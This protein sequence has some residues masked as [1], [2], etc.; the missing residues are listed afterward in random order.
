MLTSLG[1]TEGDVARELNDDEVAAI[2]AAD[3]EAQRAVRHWRQ[4]TTAP[5]PY[6][7]DLERG[8]EP[9]TPEN[10][11][12]IQLPEY[13][14]GE[15]MATPI[16]QVDEDIMALDAGD[17][18]RIELA[19]AVEVPYTGPSIEEI[20]KKQRVAK[21][22]E[23]M[24]PPGTRGAIYEG[25]DGKTAFLYPDKG[26]VQIYD[27][28][29][30][31][32]QEVNPNLVRSIEKNL[33][34]YRRYAERINLPKPQPVQ[35]V[36]VPKKGK[37]TGQG[38]PALKEPGLGSGAQILPPGEVPAPPPPDASA[39]AMDVFTT[40]PIPGPNIPSRVEARTFVPPL[41]QASEAVS[42]EEP[43]TPTPTPELPETPTPTTEQPQP[44]P[45]T[46]VKLV[47]NDGTQFTLDPDT[48]DITH[49]GSGE[50]F[51]FGSDVY[52]NVVKVLKP[53]EA[54]APPEA[55]ASPEAPAP[56]EAPASPE[57]P[58]TT[59]PT[60]Q[61]DP[62]EITVDPEEIDLP[63]D[64]LGFDEPPVAG[65]EP[66]AEWKKQLGVAGL[67]AGMQTAVGATTF[68]GPAA[69]YERERIAELERGTGTAAAIERGGV[70]AQGQIAAMETERRQ[71][72]EAARAG[73]GQRDVAG[74]ERGFEAQKMRLQKGAKDIAMDT[75]RTK[76]QAAQAEMN[77]LASLYAS[78]QERMDRFIGTTTQGI[79]AAGPIAATAI[80]SK[81]QPVDL[82]PTKLMDQ[83]IERGVDPNE[84]MKRASEIMRYT[85][86]I[87]TAK[88]GS[89]Q[90]EQLLQRMNQYMYQ[91]GSAGSF[92]A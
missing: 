83:A 5:L 38:L 67:L 20:R 43:E 79:A 52:K 49:D 16:D 13:E 36:N 6:R 19:E 89:Q 21:R 24:T 35:V 3:A 31:V 32:S 48:L 37:I 65:R 90:Q 11:T 70:R 91:Q 78:K 76:I 72:E 86:Q 69:R 17:E 82:D 15:E 39:A 77:E 66:T 59:Q 2:F 55:P 8:F 61:F 7:T 29:R 73:M 46:P 33:T 18:A 56:P 53:P 64:P 71:R 75:E 45:S 81:R 58:E 92:R 57:A 30:L 85:A 84:A 40:P 9:I 44:A 87:E 10:I 60:E 80:A 14:A 34:E 42:T 4:S 68:L 74:L 63:I 50:V 1:T 25:P 41:Q 26:I 27:N 54:S 12:G 51:K 23:R 22:I 28:G 62:L 88:M 47:D